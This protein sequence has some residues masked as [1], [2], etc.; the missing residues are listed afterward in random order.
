MKIVD[1][2][3][4]IAPDM[5]KKVIGIRPGEKIHEILITESDATRTV[6]FDGYYLIKPE[7]PLWGKFQLNGGN[8]VGEE[9]SYSSDANSDWMTR[10]RMVEIINDWKEEY[11]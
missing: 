8:L 9:F 6:E 2:A 3:D 10:E 1:L 11:E 4:V 5:E 7:F